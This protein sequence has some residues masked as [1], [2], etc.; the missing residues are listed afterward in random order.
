MTE[1]ERLFNLLYETLGVGYTEI[2]EHTADYLL[3]NGV[4]V[5]PCKV[6]DT[7]YW[8]TA[9]DSYATQKDHKGIVNTIMVNDTDI[10]FSTQY[11]TLKLS[12]YRRTW[13][14]NEDEQKTVIDIMQKARKEAERALKEVQ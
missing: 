11:Q 13:F 14:V 9:W 2:A 3:A 7:V 5:L 6:G 8:V 4:I 12:D 1:R 10:Y